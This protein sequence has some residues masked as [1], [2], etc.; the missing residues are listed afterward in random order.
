MSMASVSYGSASLEG[1]QYR[2]LLMQVCSRY[3]HNIVHWTCMHDWATVRLN[4]ANNLALQIHLSSPSHSPPTFM[5]PGVS[6]VK[7]WLYADGMNACWSIS[8]L[9]LSLSSAM[10][11]KISPWSDRKISIM[12]NPDDDHM[13]RRRRAA[14]PPSAM[15]VDGRDQ[16]MRRSTKSTRRQTESSAKVVVEFTL[17]S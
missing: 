7:P 2:C 10:R 6:P 5:I 8:R 1:F 17:I 4:L 12:T 13:Q 11:R 3:L 15:I 14:L 9:S 16:R